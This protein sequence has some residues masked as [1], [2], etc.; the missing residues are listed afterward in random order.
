MVHF[1]SPAYPC[2]VLIDE[3]FRQITVALYVP[4]DAQGRDTFAPVGTA[5]WVGIPA[6][7]P[8]R[9]FNYLVTARHVIQQARARGGSLYVR[10]NLKTGGS[11]LAKTDPESWVEHPATDVAVL[12]GS[13]LGAEMK[14]LGVGSFATDELIETH[15]VG[16]GDDVFFVGRAGNDKGAA[17][18]QVR[19]HRSNASRNDRCAP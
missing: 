8:N 2:S 9:S 10:A 4:T 14:W 7:D 13:V 11:Q 1:G 18:H 12:P 16:E 19:Q 5:F 17:H 6:A 3:Q 15:K